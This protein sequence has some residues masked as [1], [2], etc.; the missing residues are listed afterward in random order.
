MALKQYK[1]TTPGQRQLVLDRPFAA[2][3]GRS[4]QGADRRSVR[5]MAAATIPAASPCAGRAAVTSSAI[6]SSISSAANSI[7]PP[8]VERLEY[9]PNR[10]AFIA[11]AEI[12]GRRA[13]LHPG[14]AAPGRRRHGD[15]RREGR[16]EARQCD[17]AR[18]DAGRHHRPQHRNEAGQ[19]RSDRAFRRHLRAV[20]RPRLRVTRSCA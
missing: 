8:S 9:D 10:T 4:G 16:R 17:A 19:G 6:A 3:Q 18:G 2:S 1:P 13:R 20:S 11:L 14:A 7:F 12:Q 15:L 5:A